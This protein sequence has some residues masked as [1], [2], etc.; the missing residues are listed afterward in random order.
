MPKK[1]KN[2]LDEPYISDFGLDD[3]EN[4]SNVVT[5]ERNAGKGTRGQKIS[6]KRGKDEAYS[7]ESDDDVDDGQIPVTSMLKQFGADIQKTINTKRR[8]LEIFTKQCNVSRDKVDSVLDSQK[9]SRNTL[10]EE[11]RKQMG[12]VLGQ[13][14]SDIERAKETE[15]KLNSLLTQQMKLL[16]Q[17]RVVQ[18]QRYKSMKQLHEQYNKSV[19]EIEESHVTQHKTVT[20]EL[21]KELASLQKKFLLETE[22]ERP[23]PSAVGHLTAN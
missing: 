21:Q 16:A 1:G 15:E 8:K 14:E 2:K 13:W 22:I 11:Y 7:K 12:T 4:E 3:A 5:S 6:K 19:T 20:D 10:Y 9:E 18:T 23:G 17:I